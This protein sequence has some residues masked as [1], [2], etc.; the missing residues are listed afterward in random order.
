[1]NREQLEKLRDEKA[2]EAAERT[3]YHR[4]EVEW[5]RAEEHFSEGADLFLEPLA[6]C[7][8]ALEKRIAWL[9]GCADA[10]FSNMEGA[11]EPEFSYWQNWMNSCRAESFKDRKALAKVS[12]LLSGDVPFQDTIVSPTDT[13]TGEKK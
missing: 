4:G 2:E 10:A 11:G 12:S 13:T 7:L 1:M 9:D 8:A 6:E 5:S 3:S